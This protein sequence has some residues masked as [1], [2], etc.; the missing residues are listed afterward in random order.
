VRFSVLIVTRCRPDLLQETLESVLACDPPPYEVIVVD[1]DENRSAGGVVAELQ[2]GGRSPEVRY[3]P[4]EPGLSVQRNR[5]VQLASGDLVVF[6]DD[7]VALDPGLFGALADAYRD[8]AVAG[9]T[10]R[11]VEADRRRFGGRASPVRRL[12]FPGG[13]QG[14]MTR[15]GYPRRILDPERECDVE[16][17][18]GCFM[19]A[20]TELARRVP[21]DELISANFEGEDEDF[22]YRL[23]RLGRVRYM[24]R[25]VLHHKL[26]GFH[27]SRRRQRHFNRDI[28]LARTYLFRKNFRPTPA[29]RIQFAGLIGI[30][31]VHRAIN[32]EWAGVLGVLEGAALAWRAKGA[33]AL[34]SRP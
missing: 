23:S 1:G 21:H 26:A 22:S 25:A 18:Q 4:S 29:A 14:S 34:L 10:G 16:W 27:S 8:P 13:P 3:L 32:R 15:F 12:L 6:L 9:A 33:G 7:D 24:P 30:L 5:G 20:R 19:S 17:M 31:I 2:G 28:V 11:V